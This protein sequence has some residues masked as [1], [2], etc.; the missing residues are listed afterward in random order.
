MK[1]GLLQLDQILTSDQKRT[2]TRKYSSKAVHW[3]FP[4]SSTTL[5]FETQG[6]AP[7]QEEFVNLQ[8]PLIQSSKRFGISSVQF[9]PLV[10]SSLGKFVQFSPG[11]GDQV[12]PFNSVHSVQITNFSGPGSD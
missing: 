10:A 12:P 3:S 2:T 6:V 5:G 7:G 1:F 4:L 11:H 9:I 8:G